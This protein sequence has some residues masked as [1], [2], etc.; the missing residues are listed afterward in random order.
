[1]KPT[2]TLKLVEV[3]RFED[4]NNHI[5]P[6]DAGDIHRRMYNKFIEVIGDRSRIKFDE[7]NEIIDRIVEE[8]PEFASYFYDGVLAKYR[9]YRDY[10]EDE[11]E[12]YMAKFDKEINNVIRIGEDINNNGWT[13]RIRPTRE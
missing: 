12:L 5:C 7:Y 13:T 1:M 10:S 8:N 3:E 6:K 4:P 9:W 11:H 2:F